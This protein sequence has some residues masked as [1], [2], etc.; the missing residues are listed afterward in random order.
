MCH[1]HLGNLTNLEAR[2]SFEIFLDSS[3]IHC[4]TTKH[5]LEIPEPSDIRKENVYTYFSL[6]I[7]IDMQL[8]ILVVSVKENLDT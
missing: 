3:V 6:S 7:K 2:D 4:L 1:I 8:K 5:I